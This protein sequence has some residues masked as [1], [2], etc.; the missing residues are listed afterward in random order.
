[1]NKDDV[2]VGV[3]AGMLSSGW[4]VAMSHRFDL[5]WYWVWTPVTIL[6]LARVLAG[7]WW[8]RSPK[9]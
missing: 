2:S 9:S 4:I 6:C 3:L 7:L 1:M 5:H 8:A